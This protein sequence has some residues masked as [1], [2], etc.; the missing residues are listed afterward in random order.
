MTREQFH[1][2][3]E[4]GSLLQEVESL[5]CALVEGTISQQQLRRLEQLVRENAAA[6][7]TYIEYFNLHAALHHYNAANLATVAGLSGE[8]DEPTSETTTPIPTKALMFPSLPLSLPVLGGIFVVLLC[9]GTWLF[10]DVLK[11]TENGPD[12]A[13][14]S[15]SAPIST[16]DPSQQETTEE[17]YVAEMIWSNLG[18][19]GNGGN[20]AASSKLAK[21][22]TLRV[23]NE[24]V[25]VRFACGA[26]VTLHGPAVFHI[27]SEI[28]GE[29]E[30]GSLEARV[31]PEA[32]GFLIDTPATRVVDLGTEF[33]LSVNTNGETNVKVLDG[34]VETEPRRPTLTAPDSRRKLREGDALFFKPPLTESLRVDF[35]RPDCLNVFDIVRPDP[36]IRLFDPE[37]G[38][39]M[40]QTHSG[41]ICST[42][43]NNRNFLVVPAPD[44]D[45]EVVLYV[46]QFMPVSSPQH[47]SLCVLNDQDNLYRVSYWICQDVQ[48]GFAFN[49][50]AEAK[51]T[52]PLNQNLNDNPATAD[53]F[54]DMMDKPFRLRLVRRSSEI[55][56]YWASESGPW[57]PHGKINWDRQPRFVGFYAADGLYE[58]ET[59]VDCIIDA[60][61]LKILK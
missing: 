9:L 7:R 49:Q 35:D 32:T 16:T 21:G 10:H 30:F 60:F 17:N 55:S 23:Q 59:P 26:M 40:L 51:Q 27:V 45:F 11:N 14:N 28:R 53:D 54:V 44:G 43:N 50:E 36:D 24:D 3:K 52:R 22:E 34:E 20:L 12:L 48:R 8:N 56:A 42:A 38:T 2:D 41:D 13:T 6:K 58:K 31:P 29:L 37:A 25:R 15:P 18:V 46:K 61:E 39:L 57:I 47:V 19:Q 1:S 4:Q 5:C 33:G